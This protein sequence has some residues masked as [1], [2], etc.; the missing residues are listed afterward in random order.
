VSFLIQP[1]R[2][3]YLTLQRLQIVIYVNAIRD[4][5]GMMLK[6]NVCLVKI[7]VLT[8]PSLKFAKPVM[9]TL[10]IMEKNVYANQDFT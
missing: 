6:P 4:I 8:A 3:A 5:T 7:T 2:T 10:N 1:A 9:K